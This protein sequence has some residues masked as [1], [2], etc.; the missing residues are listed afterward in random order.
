MQKSVAIVDDDEISRRGLT[1]LLAAR[2]EVVVVASMSHDEALASDDGWM[3]ADVVIV[4]AGDARRTDDHFPG[5]SVVE[6][7]RSKRGASGPLII[8]ITGHYFDDA[9]RR[10][11]REASA[12]YFYHRSEVQEAAMLYDAV[13]HPERSL[14]GVPA[15]ADHEA[16]F[17]LGVTDR[18]RVNQGVSNLLRS[19]FAQDLESRGSSRSRTW[20]HRRRSFNAAARLTP[21]NS[22]GRPPDRSQDDPSLTQIE[23]F[24]EWATRAKDRAR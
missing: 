12:D 13:L 20:L 17:R 23:R 22:D 7:V 15:M 9:L 4:D 21:V 10:R 24:L 11:M 8:V 16:A 19:R 5:V 1:E 2:P 14:R 3:S 18:T 6:R